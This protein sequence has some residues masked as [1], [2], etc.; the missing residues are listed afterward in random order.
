MRVIFVL[1]SMALIS[2][3]TAMAAS[4]YVG[5]KV[6]RAVSKVEKVVIDI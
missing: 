4:A 6:G 2:L 1:D 5:Y 3:A